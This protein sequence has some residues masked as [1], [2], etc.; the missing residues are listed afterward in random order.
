[1]ADLGMVA[2]DYEEMVALAAKYQKH[3]NDMKE[4]LDAVDRLFQDTS[5]QWSGKARKRFKLEFQAIEA[6]L[7]RACDGIQDYADMVRRVCADMK[8]TEAQTVHSIE[9][10]YHF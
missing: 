6:D 5:N 4:M 9:N 1:M 10:K 8:E 3:H 7:R 2:M